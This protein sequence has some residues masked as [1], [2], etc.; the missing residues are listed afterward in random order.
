MNEENFPKE[1]MDF[2][3]RHPLDWVVD[4]NNGKVKLVHSI[5]IYNFLN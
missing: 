3:I 5:D 1:E 2:F 4:A